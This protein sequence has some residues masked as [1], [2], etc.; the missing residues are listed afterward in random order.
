MVDITDWMGTISESNSN[1]PEAEQIENIIDNDL[2][3]KYLTFA[4]TTAIEYN[5]SRNAIVT[6]YAIFSANDVP[7]RDPKDWTFEALNPFTLEWVTLHTVTNEP[8]WEDRFQKK[9]F[10]FEN[11]QVF[12]VFRLNITSEHG[13]GKIQIAE[14]E[15]YGEMLSAVENKTSHL[16]NEYVL[17]Q[18]YP[19]PFNPFTHIRFSLP[20]PTDVTISIY[21][22]MGQRVITLV[23]QPM[24]AGLH[25]LT[26]NGTNDLGLTVANGIYYV[27]MNSELGVKTKKMM[28][29]K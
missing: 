5:F 23:D 10:T 12:N 19:N 27:R 15:I 2:T 8:I 18:N 17:Y 4:T 6:G 1:S 24:S 25:D 20:T 28:F 29:L 3:T 22:M 16:P 14:L 26:W 7:E 21:N 11:T 13:E 9:E